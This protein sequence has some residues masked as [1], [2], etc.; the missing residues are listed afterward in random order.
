MR[1]RGRAGVGSQGGLGGMECGIEISELEL[2]AEYL[3]ESTKSFKYSM[4][5]SN[6]SNVMKV[7][8]KARLNSFSSDDPDPH[9][10]YSFLC[11]AHSSPVRY[12]LKKQ[13][14]GI[15]RTGPHYLR[16]SAVH[17]VAVDI[18]PFAVLSAHLNH[19]KS[20][21]VKNRSLVIH[22]KRTSRV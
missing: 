2:V 21:F 18:H 19:F 10:T 4:V 5:F 6:T 13:S 14:S 17:G 12:E 16:R 11:E 1:G 9:S 3:G 20:Q 8:S 7:S 15:S 22:V